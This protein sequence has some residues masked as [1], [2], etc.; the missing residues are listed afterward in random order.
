MIGRVAQD[1]G[2]VPT[3]EDAWPAGGRR[4]L[5]GESERSEQLL[6]KLWYSHRPSSRLYGH[7]H[8]GEGDREAAEQ[9]QCLPR[10]CLRSLSDGERAR[11]LFD[12]SA[13]VL[14]QCLSED[15][16]LLQVL[17]ALASDNDPAR[18]LGETAVLLQ[19]YGLPDP[20]QPGHPNIARQ[21]GET[22][23]VMLEAS[24]LGCPIGQIGR[25]QAHPWPKR[26]W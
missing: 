17:I 9:G 1:V 6:L 14:H 23:Q 2:F 24:K 13:T 26:V 21:A 10:H 22:G 8:A 4:A 19:E 20:A 3:E 11:T 5:A 25:L 15:G 12:C 18:R 16:L 7:G